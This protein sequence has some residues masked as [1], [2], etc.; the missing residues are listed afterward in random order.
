MKFNEFA[1]S[2]PETENSATDRESLMS[3]NDNFL[4]SSQQKERLLKSWLFLQT[5]YVDNTAMVEDLT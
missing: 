1:G 2:D 4:F 3:E 5:R